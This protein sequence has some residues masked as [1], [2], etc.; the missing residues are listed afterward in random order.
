M[1]AAAVASVAS[2]GVK[3]KPDDDDIK[4]SPAA[5]RPRIDHSARREVRLHAWRVLTAG[6][7]L[8]HAD[9]GD[10]KCDIARAV[11]VIPKRKESDHKLDA[12]IT[13]HWPKCVSVCSNSTDPQVSA[14]QRH[15]S[16]MD[17]RQMIR[18]HAEKVLIQK[19]PLEHPRVGDMTVEVAKLIDDSDSHEI[20]SLIENYWPYEIDRANH[21]NLSKTLYWSKG[22]LRDRIREHSKLV[23]AKGGRVLSRSFRRMSYELAL[24]IQEIPADYNHVGEFDA[25]VRTYWPD[26]YDRSED[27][28]AAKKA[29][30]YK[31]H[32]P[33]SAPAAAA[34]AMMSMTKN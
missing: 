27:F 13:R 7:P 14:E 30:Q 26:E 28:A 17:T 16:M 2:V 8:P 12:L 15:R 11:V 29:F 33:E 34:A 24:A 3:R 23:L 25:L 4:A 32:V 31:D 18:R 5:K 10:M 1:A 22:A 19:R 6:G 20:D 21:R 9:F